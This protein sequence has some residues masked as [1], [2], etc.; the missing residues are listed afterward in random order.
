MSMASSGGRLVR[1]FLAGDVMLARGVDMIQRFSCDPVL[2]ENNGLD[3]HGYVRLA[4]RQ[5]GKIPDASRRSPGYVWG[6]ALNVLQVHVFKCLFDVCIL[7]RYTLSVC[8]RTLHV[9]WQTMLE[10]LK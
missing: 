5:N 2:Y 3:A 1:L 6:E 9:V 7:K 8:K 4:E 10:M